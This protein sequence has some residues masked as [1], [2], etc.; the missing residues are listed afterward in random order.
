MP[1]RKMIGPFTKRQQFL[2]DQM[3]ADKEL[4]AVEVPEDCRGCSHILIKIFGEYSVRVAKGELD[5]TSATAELQSHIS[6]CT[7]LVYRT[8][9]YDAAPNCPTEQ[10]ER[11]ASQLR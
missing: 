9:A 4:R 6:D 1:E 3:E 2:A 11:E 7:G 8:D 5:I 10:A